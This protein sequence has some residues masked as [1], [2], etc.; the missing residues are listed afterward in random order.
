MRIAMMKQWVRKGLPVLMALAVFFG[1]VL[2]AAVVSRADLS[3]GKDPG[4]T[5][6]TVFNAVE[7]PLQTGNLNGDGQTDMDDVTYLMYHLTFP[8]LYPV[9]APAD[10]SQNG[11]LD[12]FD[13]LKLLY[14]VFFPETYRSNDA[15]I[16]IENEQEF[17][18]LF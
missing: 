5:K 12:S 13:V 4:F 11:R 9:S 6:A 7:D 17:G 15:V 16:F 1:F 3:L 14:C 2:N 18:L 8:D 10:F